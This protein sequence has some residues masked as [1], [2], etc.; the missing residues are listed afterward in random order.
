MSCDVKEP[1]GFETSHREKEKGL[2]LKDYVFGRV[3]S[4]LVEGDGGG[5]KKVNLNW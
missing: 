5:I 4:G 1:N 2:E 3:Q